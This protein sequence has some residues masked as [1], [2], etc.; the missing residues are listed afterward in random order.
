MSITEAF[1]EF[2]T[3]KTQ[4]CLTMCIT[5]QLGEQ[6]T[7]GKVS[8]HSSNIGG[9]HRYRGNL[10]L[11]TPF[12][13]SRPERLKEIA[14]RFNLNP[15]EA[16]ENIIYSRAYNSEHQMDLLAIL[17]AKFSEEPGRFKLL[18]SSVR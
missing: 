17:A 18:V 5:C 8:D 16:L 12:T 15:D 6:N 10:V 2:R 4:L 9:I 13:C 11:N 1:G 7:S 14:A 3:G